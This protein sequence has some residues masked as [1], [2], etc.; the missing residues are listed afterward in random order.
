MSG[1]SLVGGLG[2]W[3]RAVIVLPSFVGIVE[4]DSSML[5]GGGLVLRAASMGA[6]LVR[7]PWIEGCSGGDGSCLRSCRMLVVG[8]CW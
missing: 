4:V 2:R 3:M 1:E 5:G 6:S 7:R 8:I